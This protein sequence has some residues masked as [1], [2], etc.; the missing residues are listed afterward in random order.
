MSAAIL[1]CFA[2]PSMAEVLYELGAPRDRMDFR[3][4]AC[5]FQAGYSACAAE[6]VFQA[7]KSPAWHIY[8]PGMSP[9]YPNT[10]SVTFDGADILIDVHK[11]TM[12]WLILQTVE[13]AAYSLEEKPYFS[14]GNSIEFRVLSDR[15]L[16]AQIG[17]D[18]GGTFGFDDDGDV[19]WTSLYP[20]AYISGMVETNL[21]GRLGSPAHSHRMDIRFY[22]DDETNSVHE[23][24]APARI[25]VTGLRIN[26]H[27]TPEPAAILQVLTAIVAVGIAGKLRR[28]SRRATPLD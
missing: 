26:G 17:I 3:V 18:R 21:S 20:D 15:D 13:S 25:R 4:R 27:Y 2:S 6:T 14:V 9:E 24:L 23:V 5:E 12:L 19:R 16:R 28:A 8:R 7:G 1:L 22:V 10:A 11:P